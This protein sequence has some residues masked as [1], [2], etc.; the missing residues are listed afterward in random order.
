M[1]L[2]GTAGAREAPTG[3]MPRSSSS[4]PGDDGQPRGSDTD[5]GGGPGALGSPQTT[6]ADTCCRPPHPAQAESGAQPP[7]WPGGRGAGCRG[8][9]QA[10]YSAQLRLP[11]RPLAQPPRLRE[12]LFWCLGAFPQRQPRGS[13]LAPQVQAASRQEEAQP[14]ALHGW[15]KRPAVGQPDASDRRG[16]V[17]SKC[18]VLRCGRDLSPLPLHP[19]PLTLASWPRRPL[20]T[21]TRLGDPSLRLRDSAHCQ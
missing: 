12:P 11:G 4:G 7:S 14:P 1:T 2:R 3:S 16:Q 21:P 9:R 10:S 19:R 5:V 15:Q 6:L 8:P 18:P 20:R 13:H 17:V